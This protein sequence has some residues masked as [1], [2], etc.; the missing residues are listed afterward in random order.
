MLH[1]GT[2]CAYFCS[3]AQSFVLLCSIIYA[4]VKDLCINFD[5]Y[6]LHKSFNVVDV[7]LEYINL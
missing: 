2:Y 7:V 4:D 3:S 5:F 6:S 1:L